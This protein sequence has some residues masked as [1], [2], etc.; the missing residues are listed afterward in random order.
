MYLPETKIL[1]PRTK[2]FVTG[3][4]TLWGSMCHSSLHWEECTVI[5]RW[6]EGFHFILLASSWVFLRPGYITSYEK[7]LSNGPNGV[8]KKR[9]M[10]SGWTQPKKLQML[11]DLC[12]KQHSFNC[13]QYM[14]FPPTH[15]VCGFCKAYVCGTYLIIYVNT[16]ILYNIKSLLL[17]LIIMYIYI[18]ILQFFLRNFS[19]LAEWIQFLSKKTGPQNGRRPF[20]RGA[21][22][23][24]FWSHAA[25]HRCGGHKIDPCYTAERGWSL[26]PRNAA[27]MFMS[28]LGM[29]TAYILPGVKP[30]F[31]LGLDGQE[32]SSPVELGLHMSVGTGVPPTLWQFPSKSVAALNPLKLTTLSVLL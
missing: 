27:E 31:G 21:A 16:Q 22:R 23:R 8:P 24:C 7:C 2:Q 9:A 3:E 26:G 5:F 4:F 29:G 1:P 13:V 11:V 32:S 28:E 12:S 18:Y 19:I 6:L 30:S 14:D 17:V 15:R 25:N 10:D 20:L